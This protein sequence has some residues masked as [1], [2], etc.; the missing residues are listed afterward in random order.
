MRCSAKRPG[1]RLEDIPI[2][3]VP[4]RQHVLDV[5]R[6]RPHLM[7]PDHVDGGGRDDLVVVVDE[8]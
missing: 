6:E 1:R 7:L 4:V 5:V 2:A 8:L 3:H